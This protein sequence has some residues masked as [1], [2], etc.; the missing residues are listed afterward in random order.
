LTDTG[1]LMIESLK[2]P[3]ELSPSKESL[4]ESF[5]ESLFEFEYDGSDA[6]RVRLLA[7]EGVI[8]VLDVTGDT[9]DVGVTTF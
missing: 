1:V 8:G 5:N 6:Y 7:T 4:I 2:N 9:A 3:V